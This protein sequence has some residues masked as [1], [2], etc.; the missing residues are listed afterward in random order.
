MTSPTPAPD[1]RPIV[2]GSG[3]IL[4]MWFKVLLL[5]LISAGV[6]FVCALKLN[7]G[8][9]P[10]I[11]IGHAI[12]GVGCFAMVKLKGAPREMG[13]TFCLKF[14]SVTAYKI[15]NITL[16]LWLANDFGYT[17]ESALSLIVVW[18]FVMSGMTILAG[19]ITDALGLRRTL[20][21][22]VTL[23]ILTRLVMILTTSKSLALGCGLFPLALG[24]ALCT[25]VLVAALRRYSSP[26]Q[27]SV[28]FSV[29]YAIMNFGFM[30]AYFV[31]DGVRET[32]AKTG[33]LTLP[34]ATTPLSDYRTLLLVSMGLEIL[35][36]PLVLLLRR[37]AEMTAEGLRITP[38]VVKYPNA[39]ILAS[40]W[41][42]I[43]DGGQDVVRLFAGLVQQAGFYR[44]LIFLLMIGL[45][46]IVFNAMDYVFPT[47]ALQELGP[48]ARVG[49][50]N[51]INGILILI[52]AP[53]I[54]IL[55][56]R[57]SAY[58][59]V[60]LGGFITAFSF[61]FMV[62]PTGLFQ[63]MADGWLGNA[64]GHG[65]MEL[66]GTVHPYYIM[67]VFW[68]IMF[69]VGEAFYSPRVYE[70]AASIAPEG[71]EASYA[72]LS[73]IP[74]LIGKLVTGAAVGG[75]LTKYS[76][77][78]GARD[79]STMWLIIGLMVL[80]APVGLLIFQ[81]YIRVKEQGRA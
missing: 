69:S 22:G 12:C 44:L 15:L 78:T 19:S 27:R 7:L 13:F 71:Q 62:L 29:F 21:I 18:S 37:G 47:F 2:S 9:V 5:A 42:T 52:L 65:Y 38:E 49:R 55:T 48:D 53:A 17:K 25:P 66:K 28:A 24:E 40:F 6:G 10:G 79:P 61:I 41:L 8:N 59:M 34:L 72:S 75:L 51:A 68:Q 56:Q 31:F 16:V 67:I 57:F 80:V 1:L 43:R 26:S 33:P 81:R 58:A 54:G 74:L 14:L 63:S 76:P 35:I 50:F 60:I 73:Y 46:K 30:V 70:Y 32:L 4:A 23:A 39:G 36:L 64:I 45:L 77:D 3:P 20:I 11:V